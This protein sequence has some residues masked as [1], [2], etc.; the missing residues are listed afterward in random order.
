MERQHVRC[1]RLRL[2][3]LITDGG[4]SPKFE[5]L[6]DNTYGQG[7]M[8]PDETITVRYAIPE[9]GGNWWQ[10]TEI[11]PF[12]QHGGVPTVETMEAVDGSYIISMVSEFRF[13]VLRKI[14]KRYNEKAQAE[15]RIVYDLIEYPDGDIHDMITVETFDAILLENV[16]QNVHPVRNA[17]R[18]YLWRYCRIGE[19]IPKSPMMLL[20]SDFDHPLTITRTPLWNVRQAALADRKTNDI[21]DSDDSGNDESAENYNP[22][23]DVWSDEE[24]EEDTV[25]VIGALRDNRHIQLSVYGMTSDLEHL[26]DQYHSGEKRDDATTVNLANH[27]EAAIC[28]ATKIHEYHGNAKLTQQE[29]E[30]LIICLEWFI[31]TVGDEESTSHAIKNRI[32]KAIQCLHATKL[33]QTCVKGARQSGE[34]IKQQ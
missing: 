26:M 6:G 12:G 14:W 8:I 32:T 22:E 3:E 23:D 4:F 16:H 29:V 15:E 18:E 33:F 7:H 17:L 9:N 20:F 21:F 10:E 5:L 19:A 2:Q 11:V 25:L 1:S 24:E 28:A 30:S 31:T 27:S 34:L 13:L